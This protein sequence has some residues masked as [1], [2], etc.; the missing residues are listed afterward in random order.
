MQKQ[1]LVDTILRNYDIP[2]L[3]WRKVSSKPDKYDV[4]D[5]QQRLRAIWEFLDGEFPLPK[6]ADAIDGE[7]VANL[8]YENLSDDLRMRF[9][10]YALDVVVLK[11]SDEDEVREMFL[12]L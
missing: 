11:E 10:V 2:K 5:D 12:Q 3:Y 7:T 8:H 6:D 9:D 1:L 4:V